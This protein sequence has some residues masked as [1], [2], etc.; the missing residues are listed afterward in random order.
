MNNTSNQ[1]IGLDRFSSFGKVSLSVIKKVDTNNVVIYTRVSSKEQAD[2]NLS[3]ETQRNAIED[4][5]RRNK[6]NI[7]AFLE[8]RM[9]VQRVMVEKNLC[10]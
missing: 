6:L 10:E 9:K 3:L 2:K 1:K 8:E 7:V 4:Y 5:A